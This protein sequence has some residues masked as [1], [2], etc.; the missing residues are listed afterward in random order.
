MRARVTRGRAARVLALAAALW[1]TSGPAP[2]M[3][4]P[5]DG[6]PAEISLWQA[7]TARGSRA[8][9]EGYLLLFPNGRFASLARVRLQ[10]MG[11][12]QAAGPTA[13]PGAVPAPPALP[14]PEFTLYHIDVTPA[15]AARGQPVTVRCRGF[16]PPALFDLIVVVRAGAPDLT[17][18]GTPDESQMVVKG[19][20][21]LYEI[22]RAG[23]GI[24]ALP[25]GAYEVRY[26]SRQYNPE[27]RMEV[28]ARS[29]L[30]IQ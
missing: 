22:E 8:D 30:T 15:V 17:A 26:F 4:A 24:P 5:E 10:A 9:Y 3:A 19:L 13:G 6:G 29:G 27:G 7:V 1:L 16:L 25:P 18:A 21:H 28:M 23:V 12:G 11:P 14:A 20:A 2:V